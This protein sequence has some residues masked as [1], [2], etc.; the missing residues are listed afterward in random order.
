M[1]CKGGSLGATI[2]HISSMHNKACHASDRD[3]MTVV[4]LSHKGNEFS[5]KEEVSNNVNIEGPSDQSF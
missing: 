3:D 5:H 1:E 2:R 4:P